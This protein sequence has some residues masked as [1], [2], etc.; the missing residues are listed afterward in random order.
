V[1]RLAGIVAVAA[2][3]TMLELNRRLNVWEDEGYTLETTARPPLAAA[4]QAMRFE[5]YPPLYF[6]LL[7]AWRSVDR[8]PAFARAFSTLA[9]LGTIRDASRVV[10]SFAP[11][12]DRAVVAAAIAFHP[13]VIW[14]GT[15]ARAYASIV[16]ISARILQAYHDA[17]VTPVPS[18]FAR[19]RFI[20]WS[21]AGVYTHYYLGFLI[22][23]GALSTIACP[24]RLGAFTIDAAA[25]AVGFF[26]LARAV[27]AQMATYGANFAVDM[28]P[29]R[30]V[31]N[32]AG[33]M[34]SFI[35]PSE[36]TQ[37]WW[38]PLAASSLAALVLVA[39]V[40]RRSRREAIR[41]AV[42]ALGSAVLFGTTLQLAK[43]PPGLPQHATPLFV[44][45]LVAVA[46]LLR[47]KARIRIGGAVV[48]AVSLH[49]LRAN[50]RRSAKIGDWK[51]V[52]QHVMIHECANEPVVVFQ[53]E[54]TL[55]LAHQYHGRNRLAGL[56]VDVAFD[57]YDLTRY[58]LRD[59]EQI[60]RALDR[61]GVL[62]RFWLVTTMTAKP[63]GNDLH[64]EVL[65]A[66][67]ERH[68]TLEGDAAFYGS[69]VRRFRRTPAAAA[70]AA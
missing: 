14:C 40:D 34:T 3:G 57:R 22:A 64:P 31:R 54:A 26:P 32:V 63:L 61:I 51:R 53:P 27:R 66:W 65:D 15:E 28:P 67:L 60:D 36:G 7:S 48:F 10:V 56:P 35:M 23:G 21:L 70:G 33:T 55:P 45:T 69:R 47:T 1:N 19:A 46:A 59:D 43:T 39:F 25:I 18:P 4:A 49:A 30:M 38:R 50:L 11:R 62:E 37:R 20:A 44:P 9:A 12:A 68:A 6:L 16:W 52:A 2:A 13:T 8:S 42:M 17:Y 29:L 24:G 5:Q 41:P 58:A